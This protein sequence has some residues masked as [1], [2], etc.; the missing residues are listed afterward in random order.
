VWVAL[1]PVVLGGVVYG[2]LVLK[3]DRKIYEELK[4]IMMQVNVVW[5]E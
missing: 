5:P 4:G 1:V 2:V 3:F